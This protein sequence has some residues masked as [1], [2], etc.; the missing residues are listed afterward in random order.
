MIRGDRLHTLRLQ[1]KHTHERLASL[2]NINM[3][4]V[5]RYKSGEVDLAGMR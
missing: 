4:M 5:T 2:L 1:N 3:R